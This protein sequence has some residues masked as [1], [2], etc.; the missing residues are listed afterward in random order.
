MEEEEPAPPATHPS[1]I[2]NRSKSS[3]SDKHP[4]SIICR[5]WQVADLAENPGGA[6][7][8]LL[9]MRHDQEHPVMS[10]LLHTMLMA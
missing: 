2:F 9:K 10:V 7:D 8:G 6:Y 3:G 5:L 1:L 4:V